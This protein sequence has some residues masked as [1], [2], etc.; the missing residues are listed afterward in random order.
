[1]FL[2]FFIWGGW[3]V[4]ITGWM[5]ASGL[6]PLV[7]WVFSV[8]PI[9]AIVSPL[10]LG[11][12]ADRFFA[13]QKVLGLLHLAGAAIMISIPSVMAGVSPATPLN[14]S[15]PLILLLMGYALCYMPTLGLTSSI[16]MSHIASAGKQFP[17]IRVFG[18]VGWIVA[19]LVVSLCLPGGD[20]SVNQFYVVGAA[21]LILGL[22]SFVLPSTPPPL[23][24]TKVTIGALLGFDSLALLKHKNYFIFM[25]ACLLICIP[26]SGY[27]QQARN[28]VD[29]SGMADPS[30]KMTFG[31]MSEVF[32]MAIMPFIVLKLG[33]KR[34]L[35]AGMLAWV[36]RYGLFALGANDKILW[37]IILGIVLHGICYDFFFVAGQIYVDEAASHKIRAQA[38]SF[39][40]LVTQGVGMLIGAQ[41]VGKL[42]ATSTTQE[43]VPVAAAAQE[44][45]TATSVQTT[46]EVIAVAAQTTNWFFFWGVLAV[47]A[48]AIVVFFALFF[49]DKKAAPG[50]DGA[51]GLPAVEA[52]DLR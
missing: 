43:M 19:G 46:Q 5:K 22:L 17:I 10:F 11:M 33:V 31:Q 29:F 21:S 25:L 42:M 40:V 32:F 4:P 26:L 2:Q 23:A 14:F 27:Y 3:Y 15:H 18:T 48:L 49:K 30:F 20:K 39:Y 38:Q 1:M 6:D 13:S 12:V 35:I 28:F 51:H 36:A 52:T 41:V 44:T 50:R 37:M 45:M 16:A 7:A 9:A 8:C 24:G 47:A 34:M